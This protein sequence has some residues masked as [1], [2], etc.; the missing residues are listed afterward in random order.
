M[1][2]AFISAGG[3]AQWRFIPFDHNQHQESACRQMAMDL[4]FA[5]F[6]NIDE[7]RNRGAVYTR[8][9]DSVIG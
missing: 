5:N 6:I 9:G 8:S 3:K 7:G 2:K 1:P 4:G